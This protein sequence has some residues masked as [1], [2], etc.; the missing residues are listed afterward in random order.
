[1]STAV[2][3]A[4]SRGKR[5]EQVEKQGAFQALSVSGTPGL[6]FSQRGRLGKK[7]IFYEFLGIVMIFWY[8]L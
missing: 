6:C 8:K 7:Y 1:M 5:R 3:D 2:V 4:P